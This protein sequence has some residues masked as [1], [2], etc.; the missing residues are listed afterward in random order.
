[1]VFYWTLDRLAQ[2]GLSKDLSF[3]FYLY[4]IPNLGL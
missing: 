2:T 4:F 1:L 3:E